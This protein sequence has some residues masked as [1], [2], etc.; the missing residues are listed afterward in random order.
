MSELDKIIRSLVYNGVRKN[1]N[2][3]LSVAKVNTSV[4][5]LVDFTKPVV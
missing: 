3:S 4:D 5:F 2:Q 1:K